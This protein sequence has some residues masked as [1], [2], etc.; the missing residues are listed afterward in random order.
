MDN[1]TKRP[2]RSQAR[3]EAAER[4]RRRVLDAGR[5]LFSRKGIDSTTMAHVAERAGVS[6]P[7]VYSVVKSK[8]GLLQA[9]MQEALFG[10]RFR[11]ALR[12]LEGVDDPVARIAL[13]A[14]VSRAIYEAE[15]A[16]LSLLMKASAFSQELRKSQQSFEALRRKM[17][18]ERVEALFRSGRARKGL[19]QEEAATVLWMYTSR[20]VYHKLVHESGWHPQRYEDWLQ[21]TLVE[22][23]TDGGA[24]R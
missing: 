14:R 12:Q 21:S 15:T 10:E 9:L 11:Q 19:S 1:D 22:A 2:Y 7:T 24:P 5:L 4:T 23:L 13:T 17:Q 3:T 8:A 18:H 6:V 16:E 20:E